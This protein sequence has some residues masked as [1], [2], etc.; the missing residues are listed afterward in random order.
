[1]HRSELTIDLGAVR[2]NAQRLLRLLDGAELWAVVKADGYGHGA[3]DVAGA[4]WAAGAT[5]LCAATVPEALVLRRELPAARIIVLGPT[6]G[7]EVQQAREAR[8]ELT[9]VTSEVPDGVPVHLKLDTGM[10]RWGV[11]ELEAGGADVVGVMSHLASADCDAA[12]T[13]W[14]V[15]RFRAATAELV[16]VQRHLANSAGALRYPESRFDAA[17]CGIALYGLS[18]FGEDPAVDGLEAALRWDSHLAHVKLLRVGESTGYGRRFVAERETWIGIVPVGYADGFRRDLTGT[19]VRVAGEPRRVV[20]TIS[21]D[22]FAVRARPRASD[23][24]ARRPRRPR[25]PARVAR[26][27]GGD[28]HVRAR[29]RDRLVVAPLAADGAPWLT[30][31]RAPIGTR[32]IRRSAPKSCGRGSTASCGSRATSGCSTSAPA[33]GRSRSRSRRWL[34]RWSGSTSPRSASPTHARTPRRTRRSS[35]A[36]RPAFPSTAAA[37]DLVTCVRT[38]HHVRR[39]EVV[40]AELV[41]VTRPGGRLLV[42]DQLAP[43]EPL[44]ALDLDRFERARDPTHTRL[45]MDGDLRAMFEMNDLV[46]IANETVRERRDLD[47]YLDLAVCEGDARS[48]AES[49]APDEAVDVEVG[50]YLLRR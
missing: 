44:E 2:R 32:S 25:R 23:R 21:M 34:G 27:R 43:I 20:G 37:F 6:S 4:A 45:L 12:Y 9:A 26:P 11:S 17:R 33:P 42:V 18:P 41:R 38:L 8:L 47:R 15:D 5:A 49:L 36:T 29:V 13:R 3:V 50:W 31:A 16:G 1:M 46:T 24:N 10:G 48:H 30:N 40:L 39:P 7:R 22:A 14:Q 28:D 35:R 19:E